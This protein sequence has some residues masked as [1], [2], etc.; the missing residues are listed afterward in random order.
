MVEVI[1]GLAT[2]VSVNIKMK[3][4]ITGA[5]RGLGRA[6]V[7]GLPAAGDHVTG[8][9]RNCTDELRIPDGVEWQWVQAD[10]SRAKEA[11]D[12]IEQ[13]VPPVLDVLICNLGIWEQQAFTADYDFP[14]DS[15]VAIADLIEVNVTGTLLLIKR[16]L[17]RLLASSRPR[18][19]LT[20]STS[21][22]RQCGRPEVA[23]GASKFALT[24]MADALREGYRADGLAVSCLQLGYLNT[25]DSLSV[26]IDLA[27]QRG[28]G[29]LIP[30]HDVVALVRSMLELSAASFVRELV[31][32]AIRDERF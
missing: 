16:L 18:I 12:S 9:S 20:G 17:P 5:S 10:F 6:F 27:A 22:L 29:D 15:D 14:D 28:G 7:E 25:D 11:V 13:R 21:G 24:G 2:Y 30:M 26:P 4:L 31:L 19:I 1:G 8:V 23:F 3:M 32:P